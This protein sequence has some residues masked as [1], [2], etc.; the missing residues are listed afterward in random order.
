M[1][2]LLKTLLLGALFLMISVLSFSQPNSPKWI[3]SPDGDTLLGFNSNLVNKLGEKLVLKNYLIERDYEMTKLLDL[4]RQRSDA[5]AIALDMREKE[6]SELD[7][8]I[9]IQEDKI[10]FLDELIKV[11][12]K[13][14]KTMER[15]KNFWKVMAVI[16]GGVVV[17]VTTVLLIVK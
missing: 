4:N 3:A 17:V 10:R 16:E 13:E 8:Q 9:R 12:E 15:K 2:N 1:G 5:L 14:V 11:K 6:V 7:G